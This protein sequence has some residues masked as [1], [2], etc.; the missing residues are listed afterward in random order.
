M[1]T[2]TP[3]QLEDIYEYFGID[4]KDI[5]YDVIVKGYLV[6][7]EHGSIGGKITNITNDDLIMTVKIVLAHLREGVGY[8]ELLSKMEK[9]LEL[10]PKGLGRKPKFFE[11]YDK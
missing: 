11:K 6:E 1:E 7:L 5:P 9:Q 4:N 3:R 2:L 10:D 8:Y